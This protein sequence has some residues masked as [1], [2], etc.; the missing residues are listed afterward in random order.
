MKLFSGFLLY[1]FLSLTHGTASIDS[2]YTSY[3]NTFVKI[4]KDCK[5][6]INTSELRIEQSTS[7][8]KYYIAVCYPFD[9]LIQVNN[10][11]WYDKLTENEREQTIFHEMGH[12]LLKLKHDDQDLNLM[13][14]RGFIKKELYEKEYDYFIRKLFKNCKKNLVEK[15]NYKDLHDSN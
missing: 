11:I 15:F 7:L 9:N 1:L 8:K 14:S 4:A 2:N 6:N 3:Y 13:N 5:I 12:C 10:K